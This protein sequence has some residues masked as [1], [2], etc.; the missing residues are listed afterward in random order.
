MRKVFLMFVCC[1]GLVAA[2]G[3]PEAQ[4]G[5]EG[6]AKSNTTL[7]GTPF[8]QVKL[9]GGMRTLTGDERPYELRLIYSNGGSDRAYGDKF[10]ETRG[11]GGL[12]LMSETS[13]QMPLHIGVGLDLQFGSFFMLGGSLGVGYNIPVITDQLWLQLKADLQYSFAYIGMG[14]VPVS[15]LRIKGTTIY[16]PEL[17]V[18]TSFFMLRPEVNTYFRI[19]GEVL[20][21]AGVG[22]QLPTPS[23]KVEFVFSGKDYDDKNVSER[24]KHDSPNVN[25]QLDGVQVDKIKVTSKGII[26]NVAIAIEI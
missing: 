4:S 2:D 12:G 23:S 5:G 3:I 15:S 16:G 1:A 14:D 8:L 20:L 21:M 24:L 18:T 13:I 11:S 26:F 10:A 25:F 9:Y 19:T 7:A 17:D 22:Y 6:T